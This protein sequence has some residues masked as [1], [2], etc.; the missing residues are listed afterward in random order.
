MVQKFVQDGGEGQEA[1]A[2]EEDIPNQ[3]FPSSK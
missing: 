1:L 3:L 2:T